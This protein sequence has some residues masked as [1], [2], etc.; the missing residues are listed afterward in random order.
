LAAGRFLAAAG[1]RVADFGA[2]GRAVLLAGPA[3]AAGFAA[4]RFASTVAPPAGLAGLV[5]PPFRMAA[6]KRS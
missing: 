4:T 2:T 6:R 5:P 1:F 3:G